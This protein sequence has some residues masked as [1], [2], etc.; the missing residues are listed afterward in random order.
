MGTMSTSAVVD[1]ARGGPRRRAP[2][3]VQHTRRDADAVAESKETFVTAKRAMAVHPPL[4]KRE[5]PERDLVVHPPKKKIE[6][7]AA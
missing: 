7:P 2:T 1:V 5:I 3:T 6:I 4:K